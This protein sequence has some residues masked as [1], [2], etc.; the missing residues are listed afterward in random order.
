M[1]LDPSTHARTTDPS[2]SHAAARRLTDKA[3]MMR[4]LLL[5]FSRAGYEGLTAEQA[6]HRSGYSAWDGA[7]KRV[8]DLKRAGWIEPTGDTT[9][10]IS[11]RQVDV[12]RITE[13]GR[14]Q[15]R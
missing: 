1:T 4:N 9:G 6:G 12:L 11:G 5:T 15:L 7:W 13:E 3:T 8:S 2:T 10:A 14:K